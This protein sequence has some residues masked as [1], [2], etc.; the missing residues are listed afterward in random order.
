MAKFMIRPASQTD[1][2]YLLA[3]FVHSYRHSAFASGVSNAVLRQLIEPLLSSWNCSIAAPL[4]Q[5]EFIAAWLL[6]RDANTVG[7]IHV[8]PTLRNKG[9][10]AAL[11]EQAGINR[12]RVVAAFLPTDLEGATGSFV[13][14]AK[15]HGYTIR[16]RP[17]LP[18]QSV[19]DDFRALTGVSN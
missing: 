9:L 6:Y 18:L 13:T 10:A 1:Y 14:V 17:Y 16:F 7:W 2:H 5:P 19:V 4:D 12:G 11:L 3:N 15:E 8:R